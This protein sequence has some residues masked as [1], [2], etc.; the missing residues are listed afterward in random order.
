MKVFVCCYY[1]SMSWVLVACQMDHVVVVVAAVGV[2]AVE[3][4]I[5]VVEKRWMEQRMDPS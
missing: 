2:V 3:I 1:S 4:V 5:V